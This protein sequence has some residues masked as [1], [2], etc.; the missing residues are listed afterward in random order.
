MA[1]QSRRHRRFVGQAED[2]AVRLN[3]EYRFRRE[4]PRLPPAPKLLAIT[5]IMR[6]KYCN[7][8]N[9]TVPK[10]PV[11]QATL[12]KPIIPAV[13]SLVTVAQKDDHTFTCQDI[14]TGVPRTTIWL[15]TGTTTPPLPESNETL[16]EP[17]LVIN[18][19][20]VPLATEF[21]P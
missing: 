3:C 11:R 20:D 6:C 1:V 21:N 2:I 17:K 19:P 8:V 5:D 9:H 18:N 12:N 14:R 15:Q 10:C 13:Q 7:K 16:D 4:I